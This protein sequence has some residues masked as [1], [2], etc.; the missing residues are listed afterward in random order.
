M[1]RS[2]FEK[3]RGKHGSRSQAST[4]K[5]V[6]MYG[7]PTQNSLQKS[8]SCPTEC[9]SCCGKVS[10]LLPTE[11]GLKSRNRNEVMPR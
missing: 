7:L 6:V 4:G 8:A 5:E 2:G 3:E 11:D 10:V 1:L 9:Y